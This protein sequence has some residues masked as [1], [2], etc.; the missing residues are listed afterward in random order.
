[1]KDKQNGHR[2]HTWSLSF[3]SI[4]TDSRNPGCVSTTCFG[5]LIN[6]YC[7]QIVVQFLII[8]KWEKTIAGSY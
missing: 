7:K 1:M 2:L 8:T 6:K 5:S 4:D 3:S